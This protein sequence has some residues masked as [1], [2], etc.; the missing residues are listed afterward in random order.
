M[1][2]KNFSSGKSI[3]TLISYLAGL[4]LGPERGKNPL[5]NDMTL[6]AAR[7]HPDRITFIAQKDDILTK[8]VRTETYRNVARELSY[9]SMSMVTVLLL[10]G[11]H[12]T[13]TYFPRYIDRLRR[14]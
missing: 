11:S 5:L 7:Q 10:N 2:Q 8:D 4:S 1:T 6:M 9:V 12:T 14:V 13:H 3:P